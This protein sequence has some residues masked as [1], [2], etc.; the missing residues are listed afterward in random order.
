VDRSANENGVD[1]NA[2]SVTQCET[3]LPSQSLP[4]P[5]AP[6]KASPLST[7]SASSREKISK[8]ESALGISSGKKKKPKKKSEPKHPSVGMSIDALVSKL[9]QTAS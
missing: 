2:V 5:N 8:A 1:E 3:R 4:E 7:G 6:D 9:L